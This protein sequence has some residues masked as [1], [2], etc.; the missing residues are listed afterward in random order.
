[1]PRLPNSQ[2]SSRR[3]WRAQA[4]KSARIVWVG[5]LTRGSKGL[6]PRLLP[7]QA[8]EAQPGQHGSGFAEVTTLRSANQQGR[9]P[10]RPAGPMTFEPRKATGSTW[11]AAHLGA[12]L[13]LESWLAVG[14]VWL[15]TKARWQRSV[16]P[17]MG[18]RSRQIGLETALEAGPEV[19]IAAP[20]RGAAG[21]PALSQGLGWQ[22]GR[23]GGAGSTGRELAPAPVGIFTVSTW[24]EN[25][26]A[27]DPEGGGEGPLQ[28]RGPLPE[29]DT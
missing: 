7:T 19:C 13:C 15:A 14:G 11:F 23:K 9:L 4:I 12:R 24:D 10:E 18:R 17:G 20:P 5:Q 6:T 28:G 22:E 21:F 3:W 8:L 1:M 2:P 25:R 29:S 16:L 27:R 26:E